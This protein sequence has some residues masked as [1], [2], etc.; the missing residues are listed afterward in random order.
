MH[1]DP[2]SQTLVERQEE[3][4]AQIVP[5]QVQ[6]LPMSFSFGVGR[7]KLIVDPTSDEEQRLLSF[8]SVCINS[9]GLCSGVC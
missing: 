4:Q 9:D 7:D 8:L 2:V 6:A 3:G 1:V 5:L